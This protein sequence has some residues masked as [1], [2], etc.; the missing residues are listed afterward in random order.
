[1]AQL[2]KWLMRAAVFG[3]VA[4]MI[5]AGVFWLVLTQPVALALSLDRA[6]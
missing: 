4:A 6:F 3:A 2:D 5:G 1:M